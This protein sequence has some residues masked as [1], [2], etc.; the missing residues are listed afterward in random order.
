M[1]NHFEKPPKELQHIC[2]TSGCSFATLRW[3][4]LQRHMQRLHDR[5]PTIMEPDEDIEIAPIE[6]DT[7]L[8]PSDEELAS[9]FIDEIPPEIEEE[10]P[11]P[12]IQT[13]TNQSPKE[14]PQKPKKKMG[15]P[16][17]KSGK[18]KYYECTTCEYRTNRGYNI[19]RHIAKHKANNG[20]E[21]LLHV[22]V[23]AGCGFSTPRWDNLCRHVKRVHS[24][25][26]KPQPDN[27]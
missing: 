9:M 2:P 8:M 4:N 5:K 21:L 12:E 11:P 26:E 15:R 18:T 6:R 24:E 27:W 23:I 19:K 16:R 13:V 20:T 22:C 25:H 14:V 3:D 17:K 7:D 1:T 10:Q